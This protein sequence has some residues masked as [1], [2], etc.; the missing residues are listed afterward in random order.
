L[1]DRPPSARQTGKTT[2]LKEL[3]LTYHPV[4]LELPQGAALAEQAPSELLARHP[5][6][7]VVDGV[8][9]ASALF[10]HLESNVDASKDKGQVILAG[11]QRLVRM[12]EV[13]ES[14]AGRAAV[15]QLLPFS[16]EELGGDWSSA[17]EASG[18]IVLLEP[19]FDNHTRRLVKTPK[20]YVTGVGLLCFLL[21]LDA[22]AVERCAGFGSLWERFV[23]GELLK[24]QQTHLPEAS[25]WFYRDRDGVEVDFVAQ[26]TLHDAKLG[27]LPEV[28]DTRGLL[29]ARRALGERTGRMAL[30]IGARDGVRAHASAARSASSAGASGSA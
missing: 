2:L 26:L 8:Q 24:W 16:V 3:F 9:Y 19:C 18:L 7:L 30:V 13:S 4:S 22:R 28:R 11:S 21:G 5:A 27:E 1:A 6:P 25:L 14:L 12:Q 15:L 29:S 10:R 20:L 17:L 23:F